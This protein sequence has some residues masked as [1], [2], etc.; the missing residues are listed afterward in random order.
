MHPSVHTS[1][2]NPAVRSH[3]TPGEQFFFPVI[4]DKVV[5]LLA[6]QCWLL[7]GFHFLKSC[8]RGAAG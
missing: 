7:S 5:S 1:E 6:R 8:M 3:V 2:A 4:T